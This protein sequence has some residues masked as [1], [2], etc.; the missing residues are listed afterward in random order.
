[1]KNSKKLIKI[2]EKDIT[3]LFEEHLPYWAL[4]HNLNH[5]IETV[6]GCKEIGMGSDLNEDDLNTLVIA[7]W[8]HD[9]GYLE[10]DKNHE[11]LS[12]KRAREYLVAKKIN[13]DSIKSVT[14]L[15]LSTKLKNKPNNLLEQI[16]C[17][18]DLIS[19][20][21]KQYF[22]LNEK[23]KQ[24]IELRENNQIKNISWLKRSLKFLKS[25][26]FNSNYAKRKFNKQLE[27]NKLLITKKIL[28]SSTN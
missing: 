13:E 9:V 23:L 18:A 11:E 5:T 21:Q 6:E 14:D 16:I 7:A 10:S 17:D 2:I 20:G 27:R 8:F 26:Q 28:L 19:L 3:N 1:M 25:H 15:I 24:E 12:A 4:Y 22:E